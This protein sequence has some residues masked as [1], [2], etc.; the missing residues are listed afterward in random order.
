MQ[1]SSSRLLKA[2]NGF[3]LV[4]ACANAF[5]YELADHVEFEALDLT[6]LTHDQTNVGAVTAI[7]QD[8]RGFMWFGGENGLARYDG[9]NL[10]MYRAR[11]DQNSMAANYVQGLL[12]DG[13]DY[14]WIANVGG[15]NRFNLHTGLFDLVGARFGQLPSDDVLSIAKYRQWIIV[16]TSSGLAVFDRDSLTPAQPPFLTQ[17][18]P[19]LNVRYTY[20]Y[21]DTLWLGTSHTGLIEIHLPSNQ[22]T[23]YT[24][25]NN[26][27]SRQ[28]HEIP[29]QDI[30]GILTRDGKTFWLASLG[31]GVIRF[32]YTNKTFH[33]W[34]N[35]ETA[36]HDFATND[37][38]GVFDDTRGHIWIGTDSAGLWRI[39]P[40]TDKVD[41][42]IHASTVSNSLA[43]DK[44]R[45]VFEDRDHNIW[46]GGFSGIIDYYNR[47][48]EHFLRYKQRNLF[49][50][51]LNHPS[52]LA[53]EPSKTTQLPGYW[54]GTEG[55]LDLLMPNQG[56]KKSFTPANSSLKAGPVLAL[57]A[58]SED[59][60]W[61]GTW[62]GGLSRFNPMTGAWY[63]FI[64]QPQGPHGLNAP[65]I[66][67]L[68]VDDTGKLWVGSQKEGVFRVDPD[69]LTVEHLPNNMAAAHANGSTIT[70]IAGDFI[71]AILKDRH[72]KL[73][74]TSLQGLTLYD[75]QTD[76]FTLYRH[77][78]DNPNSLVS[79]QVISLLEHSDGNI[80]VGSRD[81]GLSIINRADHS[82]TRLGLGEGLPSPSIGSL[83]EDDAG[84]VWAGTPAGLSKITPQLAITSYKQVHGLAGSN[85]N[86]NAIYF[87][88]QKRIWVG[89]TEGLT[90]FRPSLLEQTR[91]ATGAVISGIQVNYGTSLS[92][93]FWQPQKA[94][95][96]PLKYHQNTISF[97][98]SLN[99]FY[100]PRLN[101]YAYR[102]LGLDND[103]QVVSRT[104]TANYTNLD[105][106]KYRFQ[107]KGKTANGEWGE[108]VTEVRFEIK[109][110]PWRQ[111][112]AY[113][114]YT[115]LAYALLAALRSH[116]EVRA[117]SRIYQQLSHQDPLT[118]LPNRLA[119][120]SIV[121]GWLAT[122]KHFGIIIIDLDHFKNINDNY[123]HDAGDFLLREFSRVGRSVIRPGDT[124]GRWGGEEFLILCALDDIATLG[125]IAER[126]Q[127]A[128]ANQHFLYH[129]HGIRLTISAGF[130]MHGTDE[131]FSAL[132]HR[133]DQALYEAKASGR[134]QVK[135]A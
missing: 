53:I 15:L 102:L 46:V 4:L 6:T 10:L 99:Q 121:D 12:V 44:A 119:V 21:G 132:F 34:A 126:L 50:N 116:L 14:L 33:Q 64:E 61:V 124:L 120:N 122:G 112:W 54:V 63:H 78:A 113:V 130:A 89:S 109:P 1:A 5:S 105:P 101:E 17:L 19:L 24:P 97:E 26:P 48:L 80:W 16:G 104:N 42:F 25:D 77:Q 29:H 37:V 69:T 118:R 79:N 131:S 135:A 114:I 68:E 81:Q 11:H 59:S 87:D 38:T 27:Q 49:H 57:K 72:G 107:V 103:W 95:S 20:V 106:G 23:Y 43:S 51:G 18:P 93:H 111:W 52:I 13:S 84:N 28:L 88:A 55:G 117:R 110:P 62:G 67:A 2:L 134:N 128:I 45:I 39:D 73:W 71:R 75:P 108:S 82:I 40:A 32:D 8:E 22:I 83:I 47:D 31:G 127:Q 65:Y 96:E 92:K 66:W 35:T 85:H 91:I 9:H 133:A 74:I 60:L 94:I 129:Q 3:L 7:T 115:L 36:D 30:R 123:G 100:R 125:A 70:G 98:F 41:G 58:T 86:R 76:Q 56:A 90:I